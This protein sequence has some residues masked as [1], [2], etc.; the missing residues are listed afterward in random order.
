M[1]YLDVQLIHFFPL[2][3]ALNT[4]RFSWCVGNASAGWLTMDQQ[5]EIMLGGEKV[6]TEQILDL[7]QHHGC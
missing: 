4:V 2:V 7:M 1:Q 6:L 3:E 5:W